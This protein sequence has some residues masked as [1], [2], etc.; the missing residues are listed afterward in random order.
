MRTRRII[1]IISL[2]SVTDIRGGE[3]VAKENDI[4]MLVAYAAKHVPRHLQAS[5]DVCEALMA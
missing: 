5:F 1:W 3:A 2:I 4:L